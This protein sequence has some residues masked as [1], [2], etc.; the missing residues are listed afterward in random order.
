[1]R[2]NKFIAQSSQL[3]RR[4]ADQAIADGRVLVNG[5][6]PQPG[7]DIQPT[8]Q[9]TLDGSILSADD[10]PTTIVLNKP[11]GYICSRNGQ[12]GHTIYELLPYELHR[13][14]PVGRLDKDSSGLLVMT[15][16]GELANTLTHPKYEKQKK[17]IVTLYKPL[18]A[19]D[20]ASIE[21]G[22]ELDDGMSALGL[23]PLVN[24]AW[25]V[26]MHEGRNRQIRRTFAAVGH[27][28]KTLHRTT[29]GDYYL[30]PL[31]LGRFTKV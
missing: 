26:T 17:Y 12:G 8:D 22:V 13:L 3:S 2:I 16:D 14:N 20:R 18:T 11:V 30:G 9:V 24:N 28:V 6:A 31:R 19:A 10:T 21:A 25:E 1:M 15:T 5:Q 29:F 23:R 7:H 27:Q 4:A